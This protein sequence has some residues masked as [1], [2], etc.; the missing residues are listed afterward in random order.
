MLIKLLIY[1]RNIISYIYVYVC[2]IYMYI[3]NNKSTDKN[4]VKYRTDK[5]YR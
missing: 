4:T 5:Q 2:C 3:Y 1:H